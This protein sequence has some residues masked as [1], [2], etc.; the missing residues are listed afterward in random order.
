M[1]AGGHSNGYTAPNPLAQSALISSTITKSQISSDAIDYVEAHGTGTELGDPIEIRALNLA[2]NTNVKN[3]CAIGSVKSNI[4]H[5]ESAAGVAGIIKVLYQMYNEKI[6]PTLNSKTPNSYINFDDSP[7]YLSQEQIAWN[8]SD[9]KNRIAMISSFCAGG[10]NANAIIEEFKINEISDKIPYKLFIILISGHSIGALQRNI[11][12]LRIW[13]KG[14]NEI[15]LYSITY[16]LSVCREHYKYRRFFIVENKE[17]LINKLSENLFNFTIPEYYEME[18]QQ[19]FQLESIELQLLN[20]NDLLKLY[21]RL[22]K[23]YLDCHEFDWSKIY[24]V[25]KI[26]DLP[27]YEFDDYIHWID[28]PKYGLADKDKYYHHHIVNNK[29]L[30][31]AAYTLSL[32]Q[33][34]TQAQELL[35]ICWL[36]PLVNNIE[37]YEFINTKNN[38]VIS[39]TNKNEY[40]SGSVGLSNIEQYN[41][42]LHKISTE[43]QDISIIEK[44]EIYKKLA[45]NGYAYGDKYRKLQWIKY[46]NDCALG[47]IYCNPSE[48]FNID[49]SIIDS[50]L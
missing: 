3:K 29:K 27:P 44:D 9:I 48:I 41:L 38:F 22:G 43:L 13:L 17:Q 8:K 21:K 7:F 45:E 23:L 40:C 16:T 49:Q 14:K 36:K 33:K 25:R 42:K 28:Q 26:S 19:D 11:D 31:P 15:D 30:L 5:L 39:D 24:S 50:G 6:V 10:A 34:T 46:N 2:F 1:N 20:F 35:N 32:A 18:Q 37:H 47:A 4:G 12:A